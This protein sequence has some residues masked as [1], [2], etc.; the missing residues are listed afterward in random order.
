MDDEVPKEN[1]C[2]FKD[3]F[4]CLITYELPE[5]C[6]SEARKEKAILCSSR[7]NDSLHQ[8]ISSSSI[9]Y[10]QNSNITYTS[11]DHINRYLKWKCTEEC[12]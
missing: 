10:H 6:I 4:E 8:T 9:Q 2:I 11:N 1:L 7:C 12:K 5:N 3:V